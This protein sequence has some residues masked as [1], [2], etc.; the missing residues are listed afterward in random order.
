MQG[1]MRQRSNGAWELIVDI[2]RD[3]LTGKRRQRSRTFRGTKRNAQRVW[4]WGP[5]I[6]SWALI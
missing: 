6:R 2:G 1:H 3:P 5:N 4:V